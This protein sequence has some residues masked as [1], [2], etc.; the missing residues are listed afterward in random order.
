MMLPVVRAVFLVLLLAGAFRCPAQEGLRYDGPYRFEP[1]TEHPVFSDT[2]LVR[3]APS[4]AVNDTLYAFAAVRIRRQL[5]SMLT[6]GRKT[7]PW[8]EV[9]Y[10]V[11]GVSRTGALWG[12]TLAISAARRAGAEFAFGVLSYPQAPEPDAEHEPAPGGFTTCAIKARAAGTPVQQCLYNISPESASFLDTGRDAE[13]RPA[14]ERFGKAGPLPPGARFLVRFYM[15]GEACGI[16]SYKIAA[17]W[18]GMRLIR[19]PLL[20]DNADA[21]V[22]SYHE[23]YTY[24]A[25]KNGTAAYLGVRG[26]SEEYESAEQ[27]DLKPVKRTVTV[28]RYWWD[29]AGR[30]F[31]AVRK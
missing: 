4:G 28:R 19:M 16:P 13:D 1:G 27:A 8:Y 14:Y 3:E 29:G 23:A 31:L 10:R 17:A 7:A 18:D 11:R 12:G 5:P 15:S 20:E 21:G 9:D 26:V 24:P 6:V 25:V 22:W 2:A 30:R